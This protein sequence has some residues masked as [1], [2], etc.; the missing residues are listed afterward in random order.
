MELALTPERSPPRCIL[1]TRRQDGTRGG[2]Q[3]GEVSDVLCDRF[4]AQTNIGGTDTGE[5][6]PVCTGEVG[7]VGSPSGNASDANL[8][9]PVPASRSCSFL[10][11]GRVSSCETTQEDVLP[12]FDASSHLSDPVLLSL[13][14]LGLS[15]SVATEPVSFSFPVFDS[16]TATTRTGG[17]EEHERASTTSSRS[18]RS[19]PPPAERCTALTRAG[20]QCR[21]RFRGDSDSRLCG[22]HEQVLRS[23]REVSLVSRSSGMQGA[24]TGLHPRV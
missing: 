21:N 16:R 20:T 14:C 10:P 23:G 22:T 18:R 6:P 19:T 15:N 2:D 12:D 1:S 13:N 5:V 3:K 9:A 17:L 24:S 7:G 8:P 11:G 4:L